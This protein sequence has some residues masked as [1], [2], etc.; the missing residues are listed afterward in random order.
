MA[1]LSCR[2]TTSYQ[3]LQQVT[4]DTLKALPDFQAPY[5]DYD[6][7]LIAEIITLAELQALEAAQ[8]GKGGC[9]AWSLHGV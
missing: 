8:K 7:A 4:W 5:S 3:D 1:W 2:L 9:H 6:L